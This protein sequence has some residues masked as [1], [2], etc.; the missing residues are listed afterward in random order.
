MEIIASIL[1][2]IDGVIYNAI[3]YI[4][5]I[6]NFMAGVNIFNDAAY[7]DITAKIY[8]I[9]GLIMM[10]VLAYTLLKAVMNPDD[11]AKGEKS[12]PN[13]IK[14]VII[15]LV[16]IVVM[17]AIFSFAMDFQAS[18]LNNN[19]IYKFVLGRENLEEQ[20]VDIGSQVAYYTFTSFFYPSEEFC[21]DGSG[22]MTSE[23]AIACKSE[24]KSNGSTW[25]RPSTWFSN[26]VVTLAEV[27]SLVESGQASFTN[28]NDFSEAVAD[29]E[30]SYS[31]I[32]S[33]VAGVFVL[34]VLLNF[35]FDVAV[36]VIK[37]A[38][39]Q[40]IA[41][42]PIICRILPGGNM[43]DVFDKWTKQTISVYVEVFIRI[44]IMALGVYLITLVIDAFNTGIPNIDSLGFVARMIVRALLIMAVIIFIRQA[45]KLIGDIFHL[46]TGGMKLGIMDKLAMG[47]ALTAG[48]AVGGLATT[49]VRNFAGAFTGK[50]IAK[51][52]K[53][54]QFKSAFKKIGKSAVS[55]TFSGAAGAT[56]GFVRAGKA[57]LNAKNFKDMKGAASTGSKAAIDKKNKR[58]AYKASHQQATAFGHHLDVKGLMPLH[59][60]IGA[61]IENTVG[62][63]LG[64]IG[65][66][67]HK[68]KQWAGIDNMEA[69]ISANKNIDNITSS[70][71]AI[72]T[73]AE[74][75]II[76]E[77]N[78]NKNKTFGID[79]SKTF[80]NTSSLGRQYSTF[81]TSV[82]RELKQNME[83]AKQ[84]GSA[85]DNMGVDFS[86]K[87]WENLSG[88]Y[89]NE[90]TN[91][92]QNQALL[93][94]KEWNALSDSDKADL[95][96]ARI[97]AKN[98]RDIVKANLSEKYIVESGFNES[99][100]DENRSIDVDG[101]EMKAIGDKLKLAKTE[102]AMKINELRN[103]QDNQNK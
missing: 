26:D 37:L 36:R 27:D 62:V 96:D 39:Y 30:I 95:G 48:A 6:F 12:F 64:H 28:Y 45:P 70:K 75:L 47:G 77:A 25:Y 82:L 78:K 32:I 100:I 85:K 56:S 73:A 52:L 50:G 71:K 20:N 59:P 46:N 38:F 81:N 68:A 98:Y 24:I 103:K 22:N 86:A 94:T 97:A 43:K 93:S 99:I 88:E 49:G 57:G 60:Q 44:A 34:Y 13:I 9:L 80:S 87:E 72:K 53:N 15:S 92:V 90:F 74:E 33:T 102:N 66:T 23:Q 11:F 18:I 40:L 83:I 63:G 1:L 31:M 16:L 19:T 3:K 101:A 91:L 10:F 89:L 58:I 8:T 54:K 17:P 42:V 29:N 61:A 79:S 76:G 51:D 55:G 69:L 21:T 65:D 84:T 67:F 35:C 2:L 4:Y 7:Q 14:N 41:P 5:N